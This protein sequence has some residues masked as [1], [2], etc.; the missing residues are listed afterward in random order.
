MTRK[1][2]D[3]ILEK[4]DWGSWEILSDDDG[5]IRVLICVDE[6]NEDD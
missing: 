5:Y 2:V 6:E 1:E 3:A 4:L